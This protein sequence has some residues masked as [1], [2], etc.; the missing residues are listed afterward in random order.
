MDNAE[1]AID[2]VESPNRLS[3]DEIGQRQE[4][5]SGNEL[6]HLGGVFESAYSVLDRLFGCMN[7]REL[8]KCQLVCKSWKNSI[9]QVLSRRCKVVSFYRDA[10]SSQPRRRCV[11][12]EF[13]DYLKVS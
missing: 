2:S 7:A 8:L 6:H 12:D 13:G 5:D 10:A 3:P 11:D 1:I 9:E 4:S